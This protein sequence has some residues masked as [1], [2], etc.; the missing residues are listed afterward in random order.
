MGSIPLLRYIKEESIKN[1]HR[2]LHLFE[3]KEHF[4]NDMN[5][6]MYGKVY[7]SPF[8]DLLP[9]IMANALLLPIAVIRPDVD[10]YTYNVI[11]YIDRETYRYVYGPKMLLI[12]IDNVHYD[13]VG[14]VDRR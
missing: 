9:H 3:C 10:R 11:P 4:E 14:L 7:D 2:Y 5:R 1:M 8:G 12:Y 6:Y 13:G